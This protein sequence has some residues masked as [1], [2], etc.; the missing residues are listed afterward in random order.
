M[1]TAEKKK[2]VRFV[3]T[4]LLLLAIS[5]VSH[6]HRR[7]YTT[8]TMTLVSTLTTTTTKTT[9]TVCA[10]VS[11]TDSSVPVTACRRRR[12]YWIDVP[13]YIALDE[14]VDDQLSQFF[15]H[16]TA[17]LQVETTAEPWF[18]TDDDDSDPIQ[19]DNPPVNL[20][21]SQSVEPS[22]FYSDVDEFEPQMI[23]RFAG[24]LGY[25]RRRRKTVIVTWTKMTTSTKTETTYTSTKTFAISGCTPSSLPYNYCS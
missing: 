3:S 18:K 4:L 2:T 12:Q 14:D 7:R 20:M 5:T 8:I 13:L 24:R 17:P 25:R 23:G 22:W 16:P 1:G 15:I 21:P 19:I 11:S 9:N 10:S 6:G